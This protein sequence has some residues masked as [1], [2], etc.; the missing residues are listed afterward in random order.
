MT[1]LA[2]QNVSKS[3]GALKVTQD[4]SF[5]LEKGEAFGIIGPNGAGKSTLFNLIAGN[6]AVDSGRIEFEGRDV[7]RTSPMTRCLDGVGRTFQIPQPFDKLTVF[8]NLLVAGAF[9]ANQSE[10]EATDR[11]AEILWQTG[12]SP[13]AND[14]A[15]GLS[16][17]QRLAQGHRLSPGRYGRLLQRLVDK[18]PSDHELSSVVADQLDSGMIGMIE[19]KVLEAALKEAQNPSEENLPADGSLVARHRT[20]DMT[21]QRTIEWQGRESF[22]KSMGLPAQRVVRLVNP[23][24]GDV[25]L[26]EN[27]QKAAR[28]GLWA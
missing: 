1:I 3:Y 11:C 24:N 20:D 9:G 6:V 18:L 25:L 21:G 8:E 16:L 5:V 26:G 15:G 10:S 7:T 17:L 2:L 13:R 28:T 27:F 22:I 19:P 12:L 23:K 14:I 4:V